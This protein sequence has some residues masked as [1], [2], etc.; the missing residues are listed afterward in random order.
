MATCCARK[1]DPYPVRAPE[2][3][4]SEKDILEAV[5]GR[6]DAAAPFFFQLGGDSLLT[7]TRR[8]HRAKARRRLW[9]HAGKPIRS[10]SAGPRGCGSNLEWVGR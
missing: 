5:G 10:E 2:H 4:H 6:R 1:G 9:G 7:S 3:K 8:R